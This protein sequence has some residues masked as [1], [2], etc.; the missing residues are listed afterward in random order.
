[1]VRVDSHSKRN[2]VIHRPNTT[3]DAFTVQAIRDMFATHAWYP[4]ERVSDKTRTGF[5]LANKKTHGIRLSDK[6]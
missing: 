2:K 3:N 4:V 6:L 1:M 5:I